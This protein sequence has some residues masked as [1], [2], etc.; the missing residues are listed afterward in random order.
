MLTVLLV[1]AIQLSSP[2]PRIPINDS[3][4]ASVCYTVIYIVRVG[5]GLG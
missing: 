4:L 2:V 1:S 5:L 3:M